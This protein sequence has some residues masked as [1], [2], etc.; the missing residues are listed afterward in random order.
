MPWAAR[1]QMLVVLAVL[2]WS[3]IG[4]HAHDV[5]LLETLPA[6]LGLGL[7]TLFWRRF[8]W[9]PLAVSLVC[10]FG[11]V[12]CV[13]GHY[14]Y[15]HVPLGEWAREAFGLD[16]NH[17]DRLGH[18]LQGVVPAL[19]ARELFLRCT[20]LRA[21]KALFWVCV[22]VALAISAAYEIL[23]W[24]TAVLAAP[25]A[26][27]AFLGSQ[28]DVWDAQWDM[29]LAMSGALLVQLACARAHDRQV[30]ALLD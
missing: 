29:F 2:I 11:V 13:G 9:T 26:G 27:A 7:M 18:F 25:E 15:A 20:G 28:G 5:W 10:V 19:L 14:T 23:E 3:G 30:Q 6:M 1:V 8:P 21:G 12:L 22:C 24:W 4:P 16:R 17:Y